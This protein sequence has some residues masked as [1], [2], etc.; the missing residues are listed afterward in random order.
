MKDNVKQRLEQMYE[1]DTVL[2]FSI[3]VPKL[4]NIDK[5]APPKKQFELDP[6]RQKKV[7][8]KKGGDKKKAEKPM[9]TAEWNSQTRIS[10]L[11]SYQP[12]PQMMQELA[13]GV[14][15]GKR[16]SLT[17]PNTPMKHQY[18]FSLTD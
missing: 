10:Q 13:P 8:T 14:K 11:M 18:S 2:F 4:T 1:I 12:D 15:I 3:D 7:E 6:T 5:I 16:V 17:V 9:T